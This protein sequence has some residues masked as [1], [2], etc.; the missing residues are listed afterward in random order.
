ME[1]ASARAAASSTPNVRD[2]S[3]VVSARNAELLLDGCLASIVQAGP[4]EIIVVDGM[5]TDSTREVA[6]RYGARIVSDEGRG[7]PIA[8][9]IGAQASTGRWVAFVDADVVLTAGALEK[10]LE[11]FI[12]G[13]Y[14]SL[15]A[16]LRSVGGPRY[17]GRALVRHH[18]LSRQKHWPGVMATILER[19]TILEFGFD[20]RFMS[21]EDIELR[22]RLKRAGA[23]LG[24]SDRTIVTHRFAGDD[25]A[26]ARSQW[27]ADGHGL[28]KMIRKYRWHALGLLALPG[29]ACARGILLSLARFQ[30]Q[31]VP[32]YVCYV[33]DNYAGI[34]AELLGRKDGAATP[35]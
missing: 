17:W 35:G 28:G 27:L 31:W 21:G 33:I 34:L 20:E 10:L 1:I 23:H 22:H 18:Q 24:V 2:L 26:F 11:E 4:R 25:F 16:G 19:S 13:G 32:Y 7:L 3:V 5:S 30:P 15:Q 9:T 12:E 29:A 6:S 8:R 14:T